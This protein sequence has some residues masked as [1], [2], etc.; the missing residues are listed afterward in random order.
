MCKYRE[1]E[2]LPLP[3]GKTVK[4][5]NDE[6][7]KEIEKIYLESWAKGISVPFWDAEG[8][9]YLANPDGSEDKVLLNRE[10]RK[11]SV[12]ARSANPGMGRYAYLLRK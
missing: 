12:I 6:V 11:Y 5:V 7:R 9:T 8:N 4:Q 3:N 10:L 1:I 2:K